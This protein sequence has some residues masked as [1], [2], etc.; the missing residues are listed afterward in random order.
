VAGKRGRRPAEQTKVRTRLAAWRVRRGL[1]QDELAE[2]T[3]ISRSALLRLERGSGSP[4]IGDLAQLAIAL[5]CE[6]DDLLEP[7]W[8]VWR[9]R[10]VSPA[11]AQASWRD[12]SAVGTPASPP[13][14]EATA[15][16][17]ENLLDELPAEIVGSRSRRPLAAARVTQLIRL[18]DE[19]VFAAILEHDAAAAD[20][21]R[22]EA[23]KLQRLAELRQI[24]PPPSRDPRSA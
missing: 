9:N 19:A 10:K 11:E 15:A 6:I 7:V 13:D 5:G 22:V 2:L 24:V 4:R 3:G 21:L 16:E 12:T 18:A 23:R 8:V 14:P 1:T 17:I 20:A